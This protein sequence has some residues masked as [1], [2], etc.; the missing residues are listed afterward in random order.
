M[1]DPAG[2]WP[3]FDHKPPY[4]GLASFAQ[5]PW[6][7]NP[8]DLVGAGAAIVGVPFDALATDRIG[9]RDGPRAIRVASRPLGPELDT[10]IDPGERLR[11]LDYGDAPVAPFDVA[12][13]RAAIAASVGEVVAAGAAPI[14]LGGD[15]SIT[16]PALRAC[17]RGRGAV[18]L[19]HFD[20]HTDTGI[21]VYGDTDNH[22]T[23]MRALVEEGYVDPRRYVQVGLRGGWP[24]PE[25]FAWQAEIGISHFTAEAVRLQG[26]DEVV[27]RAIEIVG[28]GPTYLSVDIDVLDPAFAG[29]T[30]TPEAGGLLPRELLAAT[31]QLG[32]ALELCGA[33]VVETVLGGWG[34]EDVASLTAAGVVGSVLTGIAAPAPG[35]D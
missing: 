26:I 29:R 24:G 34:T 1:I 32:E 2:R 17:G 9:T 8:A 6:S 14:V 22:G 25:V 11:L 13:T 4:A 15:H 21:D 31:R 35:G 30:G 3:D 20:T 28:A 33:D 12:A 23:M 5:L 27:R 10:G 18:G 16:L 7:E 19:V